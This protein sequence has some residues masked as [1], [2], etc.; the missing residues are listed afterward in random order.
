L[1]EVSKAPR[2]APPPFDGVAP[3]QRQ[4]RFSLCLPWPEDHRHRKLIEAALAQESRDALAM[5]KA[6]GVPK[7]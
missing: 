3:P 1:A 7:N 2:A 5:A 4:F 6:C